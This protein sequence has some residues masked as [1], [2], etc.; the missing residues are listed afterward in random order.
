MTKITEQ[1]VTGSWRSPSGFFWVYRLRCSVPA[2]WGGYQSPDWVR[3]WLYSFCMENT[4]P[5]KKLWSFLNNKAWCT[6]D[7]EDL[8]NKKKSLKEWRQRILEECMEATSRN[9]WRA[10]NS[11]TISKMCD[12][13]EED[14]M[15]KAAEGSDSRSEQSQFRNKLIVL[16]SR[17]RSALFLYERKTC[18]SV[19][20][21]HT[22]MGKCLQLW[23]WRHQL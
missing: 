4:S 15:L 18:P 16:L 8:L 9:N 13:G 20:S 12:Q 2:T 1:I 5:S 17:Q 3:N 14:Y 23:I 22:P 11:R 7:L 21:K 19:L 6:S 10:S